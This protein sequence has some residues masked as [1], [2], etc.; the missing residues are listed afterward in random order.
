M[1]NKK[2][3]IL[4]LLIPVAIF[5]ISKAYSLPQEL[6]SVERES[7]D[8]DTPGSWH[9]DKRAEWTGFGKAKVTFDINTIRKVTEGRYLDVV[10]IIDVSSSMEGIKIEKA[11]SDAM[12]LAEYLLSDSHNSMALITFSDAASLEMS[13]TNNKTNMVNAINELSYF[14]N[15]NYDLAFKE[16]QDLMPNYIRKENTDLVTLFLTE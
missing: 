12:E 7:E 15:T 8:Y 6:K 5:F 2:I 16:L 9:I 11:K 14:G 10:L 4:L 3:F 13:F 1:K